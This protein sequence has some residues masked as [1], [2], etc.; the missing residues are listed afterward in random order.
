MFMMTAAIFMISLNTITT[1]TSKRMAA[2]TES[3]NK[4]TTQEKVSQPVI[5]YNN[6]LV[7][8]DSE[9][10]VGNPETRD[11]WIFNK[12][13]G[14]FFQ[15][16]Q[17]LDVSAGAKPYKAMLQDAIGW[18]YFSTEFEDNILLTDTFR[19]EK[20]GSTTKN[21]KSLHD[22]VGPDIGH[23]GAPSDQFDLVILTEVRTVTVW[24]GR[25]H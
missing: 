18:R 3:N 1:P 7:S 21:M 9:L 10:R 24:F 22:F 6:I 15:G 13:K 2:K 4:N 12:A 11:R 14:L 19:S 16:G 17:M 8:T 23:T 25:V 20:H 5:D